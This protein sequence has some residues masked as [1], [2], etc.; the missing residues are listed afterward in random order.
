MSIFGKIMTRLGLKKEE[1]VKPSPKKAP[2][3]EPA[4][5]KRGRKQRPEDSRPAPGRS[6]EIPVVDVVSKLEMMAEENP[7][8]LNWRVSI[9][10]LLKL[11][12]LDSSFE[13]R[14][15]LAEELGAPADKMDESA[16]M[17]TWLHQT[18]LQKI[19]ENGGNIPRELLD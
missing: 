8:E 4:A 10:D 13:A 5:E 19:A 18:V 12:D 2:P 9:V 7:Q 6:K 14:K 3:A 15:E 16:E 17:N 11:L 1:E